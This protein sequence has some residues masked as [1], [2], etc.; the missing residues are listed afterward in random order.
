MIL[1]LDDTEAD[2]V[3]VVFFTKVEKTVVSSTI[4]MMMI[5]LSIDVDD[6]AKRGFTA[7]LDYNDS[8]QSFVVANDFGVID[9]DAAS[10]GDSMEFR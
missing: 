2:N 3:Y 7:T 8:A 10:V 6:Y 5:I 9:M 1:T 4:L